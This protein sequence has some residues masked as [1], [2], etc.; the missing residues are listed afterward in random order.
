ML[1]AIKKPE[2]SLIRVE[3]RGT[4]KHSIRRTSPSTLTEVEAVAT[5]VVVTIVETTTTISLT[6]AVAEAEVV[7]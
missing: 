7:V 5:E 1:K 2:T 3:P 6:T 4:T